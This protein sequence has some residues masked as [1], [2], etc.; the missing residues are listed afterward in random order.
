MYAGHGMTETELFINILRFLVPT[1]IL[2]IGTAV[3]TMLLDRRPIRP[4][5]KGLICYPVFM[6]T[7]LVINFKCHF[8]LFS[9]FK[10]SSL[11]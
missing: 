7:W 8:L 1:F 11:L 9:L 2:P 6:G 3:I 4:M 10:Y 5:L